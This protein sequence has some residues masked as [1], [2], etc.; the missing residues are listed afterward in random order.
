MEEQKTHSHHSTTTF[1]SND[2]SYQIWLKKYRVNDET[3]DE[4]LERVSDHNQELKELISQSK[5]LFGGRILA[6]INTNRGSLSNCYSSGY[7]EDNLKDIMR[8]N[9]DLALTY[10]KQGGQGLSL[11]KIRPKGTKVGTDF[12]SDGIIPF[13]EIYN[14]TTESISQGAGRRAM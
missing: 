9:T 8:V 2:L 11:S 12:I 13:M 10:Q 7:V 6:N 1:L 4:W 5:F 14:K 3:F